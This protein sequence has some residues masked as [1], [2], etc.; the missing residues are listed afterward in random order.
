MTRLLVVLLFSFVA[1]RSECTTIHL[2]NS[3]EIEFPVINQT[4]P[5]VMTMTEVA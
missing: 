4:M 1:D 3:A 5:G 2:D